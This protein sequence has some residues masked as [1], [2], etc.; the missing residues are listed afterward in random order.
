MML[1]LLQYPVIK[2]PKATRLLE[3]NQYSF[4]ID[5]KLTKPQIKKLVEE[6]FNI[7]VLAINTH[8]PPRKIKRSGS[9]P[10]S[11]R[12]IITV[13]ANINLLG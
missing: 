4:D 1:N 10:R 6:Y 11:K 7:K 12:V 13:S 3:N 9:A 2:T 8:R 5:K